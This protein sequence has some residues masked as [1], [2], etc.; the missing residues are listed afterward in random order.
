MSEYII[1]ILGR[2]R[3]PL[4]VEYQDIELPS[5]TITVDKE[6]IS[7]MPHPDLQFDADEAQERLQEEIS[8]LL[9][10]LG[11]K[12]E[13]HN[14][15]LEISDVLYPT[16]RTATRDVLCRANLRDAPPAKDELLLNAQ[17][18]K[19]DT[20]Y[21]DLLELYIEA[22]EAPNPRPAGA[23][24]KER[25]KVRFHGYLP[26]LEQ[27]GLQPDGFDF[28]SKNQSQYKG[29][30][31]A[32]FKIGEVPTQMEPSKRFEIL[33]LLKDFILCYEKYLLKST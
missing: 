12:V 26:A 32:D 21:R 8:P 14:I 15:A 9:L 25:L 1:R 30:R 20:T 7:A 10:V 24:M 28:I 23:K 16:V 22:Q 6:I 29:D 18:T 4:T 31:H 17:W 33:T 3:P 19:T 27:L 5:F 13:K 11:A 2:L